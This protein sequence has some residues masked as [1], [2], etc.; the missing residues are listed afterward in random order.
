MSLLLLFF[1]ASVPQ[2]TKTDLMQSLFCSTDW[3]EV[4]NDLLCKSHINL[5]LNRLTD[6]DANVFVS[7]YEAILSDKVPGKCL[8]HLTLY[9][10]TWRLQACL[11][12]LSKSSLFAQCLFNC[13]FGLGRDLLYSRAVTV[14]EECDRGGIRPV[15]TRLSLCED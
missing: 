9:Y 15:K 8:I 6:C 7:L 2:R 14:C 13:T 10:C 5:R 12:N 4:A 11:C 3:L 1:F